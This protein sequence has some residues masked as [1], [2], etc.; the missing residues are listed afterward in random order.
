VAVVLTALFGFMGDGSTGAGSFWAA[1]ILACLSAEI[2]LRE[3]TPLADADTGF[4]TYPATATGMLLATLLT[5]LGL[6]QLLAAAFGRDARR[7]S[8]SRPSLTETRG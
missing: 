3:L 2:A 8:M 4:M 7:V 5:S 1:L 6:F